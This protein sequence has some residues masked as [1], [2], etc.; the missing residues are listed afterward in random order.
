M[1]LVEQCEMHVEAVERTAFCS[2][3]GGFAGGGSDRQAVLHDRDAEV[4][5]QVR[6][7]FGHRAGIVENDARLVARGGSGVAFG[8][9]LAVGGQHVEQDAGALGALGVLAWLLFVGFD[10]SA[11]AGFVMHPAEHGGDDE[12]LPR[13]KVNQPAFLGPLAFD[14]R[15][16]LDELAGPGGFVVVESPGP[17]G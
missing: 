16:Q 6:R 2:Q 9:V 13:L 4:G 12:T 1:Q 7:A 8:A 10:E 14:V 15:Q 11:Q 5:A 17:V 3:R